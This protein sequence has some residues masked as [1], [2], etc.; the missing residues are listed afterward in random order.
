MS[1]EKSNGPTFYVADVASDKDDIACIDGSVHRDTMLD[2]G[3]TTPE[4]IVELR[5]E[6]LSQLLNLK[7]DEMGVIIGDPSAKYTLSIPDYQR[8][9]CWEAKNV[10]QLLDDL[11]DYSSKKYHL[12][13]II[14]HKLSSEKEYHI[15]DGQQRIVTLALLLLALQPEINTPILD[16]RFKSDEAQNYIAHNKWL[17]SNYREIDRIKS[18]TKQILENLQFSV[19]IIYDNSLDLAYTF[20]SNQNSRGKALSDYDLLKAHHLRYIHI[21]EQAKHLA[22]RWDSLVLSSDNNDIEQ[23]LGRTFEIYLFRL[24]KWMR[25]R[26]WSNDR[27]FKVKTEFEAASIIGEI[28]PFGEKFDFYE[29]IQGGAHFFAYADH[30][31]YRFKQFAQ[32]HEYKT[33]HIHLSNERH[34]WYRDVVEAFLF[35]YYLK[36][37]TLYLTEAL[38]GILRRISDHRFQNGRAYLQSVLR[39]AADSEIVMMIDQATSPTFFLAEIQNAIKRL[40][41]TP[42]LS[43][44]RHR[45]KLAVENIENKIACGG[46]NLVAF[47]NRFK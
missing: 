13:N 16:A 25:K 38:K 45:Y 35:G 37:G 34:W 24:R 31:I 44:T 5:T 4:D 26:E 20:F 18:L 14:L 46:N 8:I 10:I 33:L 36:F 29:S 11:K 12:G 7:V 21:P 40:P 27:K 17:I 28:P 15:V 43:G 6:T 19:L 1:S 23:Q 30:F 22:G 3:K 2:I 41:V 39:Y 42:E 47:E 9:Y 32:T